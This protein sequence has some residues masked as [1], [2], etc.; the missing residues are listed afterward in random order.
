MYCFIGFDT[1]VPII[2][3]AIHHGHTL[4]PGLEQHMTISES[5]RL[6]EEDPYTDMLSEIV[7][8]RI[9]AEK[10]RFEVDLNRPRE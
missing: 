1:K 9:I 5:N 4:R 3:A 8:C 10:S 7:E 6:R 2:S